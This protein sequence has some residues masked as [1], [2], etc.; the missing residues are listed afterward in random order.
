MQVAYRWNTHVGDGIYDVRYDINGDGKIDIVDIMKV[1]AQW[2]GNVLPRDAQ[3][4]F[5]VD[6]TR[7]PLGKTSP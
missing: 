7:Y 5:A 4:C 6:Q 3:G 1:A 2:D